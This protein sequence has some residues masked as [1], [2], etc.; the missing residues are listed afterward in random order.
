[1][2]QMPQV[3]RHVYGGGAGEGGAEGGHVGH[4]EG[5]GAVIRMPQSAQSWPKGHSDGTPGP[6]PSWQM[7]LFSMP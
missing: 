2:P 5:G 3:L 7:P 6:K 1:M 4:G